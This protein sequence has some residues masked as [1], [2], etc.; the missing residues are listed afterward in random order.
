MIQVILP[1]LNEA[2]ALPWVLDRVPV[3]Y[4]PI[5]VDNASSDGSA[6]IARRLG[7]R[8]V[9]EY[10]RGFG[11]A[12]WRGLAAAHTDF[13]A[14]MDCDGSLDPRELPKVAVPVL[15]NRADL[16]CGARQSEPGAWKLHGRLAN[17]VLAFE[18]GRRAST[19]LHDIGPMRVVSRYK[20][21]SLGLRDRRSGWPVEM[22]V[23]AAAAGWRIEEIEVSYRARR[24]RSKVT[25]TL[26][27]T[28]QAAQDM[29]RVL[30]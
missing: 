3:G 14:F 10:R 18:V 11:A 4:E 28:L 13:V 5:V 24:G 1:V 15:E 30:W 7:A 23:R 12:C 19:R 21:L 27:G 6:V 20:L 2:D 25:G 9:E 17:R 26:L 16:V 22:L 29:A 8:V